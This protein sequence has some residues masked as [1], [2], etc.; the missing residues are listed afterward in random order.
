MTKKFF[1]FKIENELY[2]QFENLNYYDDFDFISDIIVNELK[3]EEIDQTTIPAWFYS[4]SFK[5]DDLK[6]QLI[7]S[8]N[9]PMDLKLI[10][11]DR[12]DNDQL[13]Q[14][15]N[16]ILKIIKSKSNRYKPV[17]KKRITTRALI[18][19]FGPGTVYLDEKTDYWI[20]A[21]LD[22]G[23]MIKLFDYKCFA[24]EME[25]NTTIDCL[26][27]A[28]YAKNINTVDFTKEHD[29]EKPIFTGKFI[30]DYTIPKRWVKRM[31]RPRSEVPYS[32]TLQDSNGNVL[33]DYTPPKILKEKKHLKP[34]IYPAVQTVNGLILLYF[35]EDPPDLKVGD[36]I[37]F[38]EGRLD[39]LAW[40]PV[41]QE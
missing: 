35:N 17:R 3:A 14:L 33:A 26:I 2:F 23:M 16:K 41:K 39:L 9:F 10:Q 32:I 38:N 4:K 11:Q 12:D 15:A 29:M 28:F 31:E 40:N 21:Q 5:L 6:F 25:I 27:L 18:K 19:D 22:N 34:E 30:G 37:S 13:R 24:R 36:V 7:M 8:D 20:I 1:E